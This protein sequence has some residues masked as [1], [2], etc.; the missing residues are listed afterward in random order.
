MEIVDLTSMNFIAQNLLECKAELSDARWRDGFVC[1]SCGHRKAYFIRT[2]SVFECANKQ[3]KKQTSATAGTQFHHSRVVDKIW[4]VLKE[5]SEQMTELCV[6]SVNQV[7]GVSNRAAR[8]AYFIIKKSFSDPD[9]ACGGESVGERKLEQKNH[10]SVIK[11]VSII[12]HPTMVPQKSAL[13]IKIGNRRFR[14]FYFSVLQPLKD[15]YLRSLQKS[16]FLRAMQNS[17]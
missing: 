14:R 8:R 17:R 4:L 11:S 10:S 7:M 5:R 12:E 3:C 1:R 13:F 2:R 16:I 9:H 6:R 15:K